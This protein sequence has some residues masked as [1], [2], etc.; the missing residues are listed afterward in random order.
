MI[1]LTRVMAID[2]ARDN[3][4]VNA[5]IPGTTATPLTEEVLL[6]LAFRANREELRPIGLLGQPEDV[7]GPA[8]FLTS[9]EAKLCT[10]GLFMADGGMTA[11]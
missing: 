1:A 6:D 2:Y 7:V 9:D 3:I 4:R 5:L 11:T 10:R 8:I